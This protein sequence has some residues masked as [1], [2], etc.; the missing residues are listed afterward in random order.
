MA[1]W[2]GARAGGGR[3]GDPQAAVGPSVLASSTRS[4]RSKDPHL[5]EWSTIVATLAGN[6]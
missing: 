4:E 1:P 6:C 3:A 5:P 2:Q